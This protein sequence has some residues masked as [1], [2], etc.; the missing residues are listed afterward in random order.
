MLSSAL[1]NVTDDHLGANPNEWSDVGRGERG[2]SDFAQR[3]RFVA[4][5]TVFLPRSVQ[6]SAVAIAGSALPANALTGVDNNGDTTLRDRPALLGRNAFRG[7]PQRSFDVSLSKPFHLSERVR[8]ELRGDV[9]NNQNYYAF[10]NVYGNGATPVATFLRPIG[11]ISNVDPREAVYVWGARVF[12]RAATDV[13]AKAI[14]RESA[15]FR[16]RV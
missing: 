14:N 9:F 1:N 6:F 3:H 4:H 10:N 15:P 16:A 2:Q 11:G 13:P 7:T 12:L 5:G 8:V